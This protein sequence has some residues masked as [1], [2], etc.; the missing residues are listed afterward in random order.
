MQL[1]AVNIFHK[2][3]SLKLYN[4]TG[5]RKSPNVEVGEEIMQAV[6]YPMLDIWL[7]II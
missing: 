5:Q 1:L 6:Q 7:G 2:L 4:E 3:L